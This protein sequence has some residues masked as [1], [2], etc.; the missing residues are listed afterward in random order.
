MAENGRLHYVTAVNHSSGELEHIQEEMHHLSDAVAG[1]DARID[2]PG[3]PAGQACGRGHQRLVPVSR[4][5][6]SEGLV[7]VDV[8]SMGT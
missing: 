5:R 3:L 1:L 2:A 8:A 7:R 4:L 6:I